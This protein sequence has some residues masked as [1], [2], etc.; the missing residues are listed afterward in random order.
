MDD[1]VFKPIGIIHTPYTTRENTPIQVG[2]GRDTEGTVVI[3]EE[4]EEGLADLDGFSHIQLLYHFHKSEG[5]KL[6]VVPFLD[7][8][9]RGLFS[10]RAPR[11][12]NNIGLS[13]TRV[14]SVEKNIIHITGI[15]V[16]D[17]TPLID[18][19]PYV[20]FFEDPDEEIRIGW[21]TGKRS[22]SRE[23]KADKRFTR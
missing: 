2:A 23:M 10:T 18:I 7:T 22:R 21:L 8:V 19:K 13:V 12:P 1:I 16:L 14:T 5:Y 17:G 9:G 15:D 3:F 20:P 4:F 11:R 6:K